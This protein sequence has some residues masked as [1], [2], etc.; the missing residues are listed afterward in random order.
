MQQQFI[1]TLSVTEIMI[2]MTKNPSTEVQG[3]IVGDSIK[4]TSNRTVNGGRLAWGMM[5][6]GQIS[7]NPE[8]SRETLIIGR[9]VPHRANIIAAWCFRVVALVFLVCVT[10][11]EVTNSPTGSVRIGMLLFPVMLLAVYLAMEKIGKSLGAA[12]IPF[13]VKFL[14]RK[15][16]ATRVN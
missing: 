11:W 9:F 12:Y 16:S 2:L 3:K 5:F 1:S 10:A 4:L 8:N 14:E 15:L 7:E 6:E 13:I